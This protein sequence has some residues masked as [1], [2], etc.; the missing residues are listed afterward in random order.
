MTQS[1]FRGLGRGLEALIP[2]SRDGGAMVPQMIAVDQIRP[3]HMQVRARFDAEPL[4]ELA[5]SIR[6][7]GVLQPLL[8]RRHVD[9]YELIAGERRWRAARR[10]GL[11]TIPAIVRTVD[12]TSSLEQALVENVQREDLSP[13]DEAAAYQQLIEDFHLT[14]DELATKVGKS[15]AAISNTLRLFQLPPSV[16]RMLAE[17]Q[18]TAGH[19]RALLTTPDRSFQESLARRVEQE[20]LSVRAVE[21]AAR[22]HNDVAPAVAAKAAPT[23]KLRPPGIHELEELLAAHLDTRVKVEM[24]AARGRLIVEP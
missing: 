17:G 4:G 20:G 12:D 19:A 1:R 15:R 9:G 18:I 14:H 3:S 21:D 23:A 22:H 11:A 10:A 5:E 8:V 24:S 16:Q 7:H 6:L 13:M 2:M